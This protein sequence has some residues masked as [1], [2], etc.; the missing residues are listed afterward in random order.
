MPQ[1][2]KLGL[3]IRHSLLHRKVLRSASRLNLRLETLNLGILLG[4]HFLHL[5]GRLGLCQFNC[6]L[7]V[8]LDEFFAVFELTVELRIAHLLHDVGIA[9]FID[10][11]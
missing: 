8:V 3:R 10:G 11:E 6:L 9:C 4:H 2:S 5:A 7:L 1:I